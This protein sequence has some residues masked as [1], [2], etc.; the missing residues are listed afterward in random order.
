LIVART[1]PI[2]A[3]ATFNGAT[4]LTAR[5]SIDCAIANLDSAAQREDREVLWDTL[6]TEIDRE[7]SED[8]T[9]GGMG[10]PVERS[11]V[12]VSALGLDASQPEDEPDEEDEPEW[13]FSDHGQIRPAR[14]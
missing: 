12:R 8:I 7:W 6:E 1:E 3:S 5:F 11:K 4:G 10:S 9:F 2:Y 14:G 13:V